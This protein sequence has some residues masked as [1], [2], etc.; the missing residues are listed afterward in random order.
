MICTRCKQDKTPE[1]MGKN[2]NRKSGIDIYCKGCKRQMS[3]AQRDL[4]IE[5]NRAYQKQWAENNKEKV[6][7]SKRESYR[8]R[9]D[10]IR[11]YNNQYRIENH[12]RRLEIER[13]S[14]SRNKEK[15]RPA[16]NSRQSA[17]NRVLAEDKYLILEREL[18][19]IYSDPCFMCGSTE[20]QSLDHIIPLSRSGTHS[21]GNIMTLCSSC[22]ASKHNRTITEWKHSKRLLGVG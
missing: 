8:R 18:R 16:K 21:V 12:E 3:Q 19:K 13:A 2:K 1:E 7:Q 22:N 9:S 11:E 4:D 17:R 5:R 10:S 14:R 20:N 6:L 15:W